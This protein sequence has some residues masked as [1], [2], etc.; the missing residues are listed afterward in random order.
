[1]SN[2]KQCAGPCGR[3]LEL[4]D[5]NFRKDKNKATGYRGRCKTCLRAATTKWA[6][7]EEFDRHEGATPPSEGRAPLHGGA[8]EGYLMRGRSTLYNKRGEIIAEWVKTA[9]DKEDEYQAIMEAIKGIA[10][11]WV[12]PKAIQKPKGFLADDLLTVIP[13]GDPHIGAFSWAEE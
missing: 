5:Q 7:V 4:N 6:H 1:M 11:D 8:P 13:L 9:K 12:K 2:T 10:D 3:V